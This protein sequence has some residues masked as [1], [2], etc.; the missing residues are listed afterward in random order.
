[1]ARAVRE[2]AKQSE[3]ESALGHYGLGIDAPWYE[4][5]QLTEK[6]RQVFRERS[7][8]S[9]E[10]KRRSLENHAEQAQPIPTPRLRPE[11]LMPGR[12]S[13]GLRTLSL[14]SGGGGLDL[15]FDRAGFEHVAS[16]EIVRD[17]AETLRRNRPDWD[18][19]TGEAGDVTQARWREWRDRV[20]V[21]HGGPPCQPFSV[22]GRQRGSSDERDLVP[23][24]VRAVREVKPLAFVAENV[25]AL[26]G[27]KFEGYLSEVLLAPLSREYRIT[28]GL[29]TAPA[30]GVPQSR[31]R[32]FIV[33]IR[34]DRQSE[35]SLPQP[36]HSFA[37][38]VDRAQQRIFDLSSLPRCMG[39][40]EALGLPDS[41]Y[42]A[43]APTV[44]SGLTGPRHTTSIVSSVAALNAWARL[45]IWPNGVAVDREKASRFP[46]AHGHFR[47]SVPDCALLQGFPGSW[48]FRGAV[49]MSLGQIGN[50]VAPPV[51]YAVARAV[52]HA[53][54]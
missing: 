7:L 11:K 1:M 28:M 15:G 54:A 32:L 6:E 42:D 16:F 33:G 26:A 49:Y 3:R 9:R 50:S 27:P 12:R 21:I 22:A 18:V 46:A 45:G 23:E 43:L 17:A 41:G 36:T 51:A 14:F 19:R 13:N 10:A 38:L 44:R 47:L 37:H 35:C 4:G 30:F 5:W 48:S 39:A 24:Y 8:R 2:A 31:T 52:A 40:R 20:D 25:A 53:L 29:L 34:R